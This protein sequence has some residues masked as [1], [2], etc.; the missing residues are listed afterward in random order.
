MVLCKRYIKNEVNEGKR[1]NEKMYQRLEYDKIIKKLVDFA[2]SP[3][4]K[5]KAEALQPYTAMIDITMAQQETTEAVS[6]ILRKGTLGLGGFREIRPQMKRAA[7]GGILS[8][9]ELLHIS[10]FLSACRRAKEYGN[11]ENKTESYERLDEFFA[12]LTPIPAL[13]QEITKCILSDVE[14]ADTASSELSKIR[15]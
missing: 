5:E 15:R 6:M 3:M 12:L 2:V 14:M 4:A 1:M 7:M 10:G 8:M 9:G 13:E 11:H